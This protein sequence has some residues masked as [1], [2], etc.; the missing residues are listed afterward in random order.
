MRAS[1]AANRCHSATRTLAVIG[2]SAVALYGSRVLINLFGPPL[3]Y[4]MKDR[5]GES[6]ESA[7]FLQ[8]L[9][10]V[11]DAEVRRSRIRPLINGSTFYPEELRAIRSAKYTQSISSPTSFSKA[12]SPA[13]SSRL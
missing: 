9:I 12:R 4:S 7:E 13:S 2:A 10:L 1:P 8:F 11:T 3:P 5:P 6:I